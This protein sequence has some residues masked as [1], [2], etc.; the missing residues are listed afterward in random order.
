MSVSKAT[1]I[2]GRLD[3]ILM[4]ILHDNIAAKRPNINMSANEV[5][6]AQRKTNANISARKAVTASRKSDTKKATKRT[7]ASKTARD[8][9]QK[10][11]C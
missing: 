3:A 2:S 4:V 10:K 7:D 5:T 6:I 11:K 8:S 9:Y 1:T